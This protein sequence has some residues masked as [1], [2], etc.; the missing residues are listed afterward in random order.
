VIPE[1]QTLFK[2][3][4]TVRIEKIDNTVRIEK[5]DNTVRIE[6]IDNTSSEFFLRPLYLFLSHHTSVFC[7]SLF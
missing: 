3:D 1:S 5:I 6:K 2:I 4:N 7:S